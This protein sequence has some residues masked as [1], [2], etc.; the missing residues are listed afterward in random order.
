M[1]SQFT[2]EVFPA[3]LEEISKSRNARGMEEDEL[4]GPPSVNKDLVGLALSGGGI[5]SATFSLGVIQAL[6][7]IGVFRS[8]DY[9]STVSGGGYIGSCLSSVLNRPGASMATFRDSDGG[10]TPAVNYLRNCSNY[11]V[12]SGPVEKMR[13]PMIFLRGILLNIWLLIPPLI[14]TVFLTELLAELW[15]RIGSP[16]ITPLIAITPFIAMAVLYPLIRRILGNHFNWRWRNFYERGLAALFALSIFILALTPILGLVEYCIDHNWDGQI[17]D[18]LRITSIKGGA[19]QVA[20][21]IGVLVA[22]ILMVKASKFFPTV[23]RAIIN[24]IVGILG[25]VWVFMIYLVFCIFFVHSPYIADIIDYEDGTQKFSKTL[26]RLAEKPDSNSEAG[27]R[28]NL[29]ALIKELE[30]SDIPQAIP[31]SSNIDS[32]MV[33]TI[34][35]TSGEKSWII[36]AKGVPGFKIVPADEYLFVPEMS[37]FNL[38]AEWGFYSIGALILA[39]NF[40]FFD[41]NVTSTHGFYRDRLSRAFIFSEGELHSQVTSN[42]GQK[43]SELNTEGSIAPYHLINTTLNLTGSDSED[44]HGRNADFFT[45]SKRHCGADYTG[46]CKTVDAEEI[47]HSLDLAT[48]MAISAAAAAPN[49]GT[50]TKRYFV[51]IMTLL[52]VRL[53]YWMPNPSKIIPAGRLKRM[54]WPNVG[55]HFLLQEAFG[56]LNKHGSHI[57][58]SDGGHIENLAVYQLLKRRC[59]LIIAVDAEADP[60]LSFNGLITMIRFATIDLGVQIDLNLDKLRAD[61]SGQSQTHWLLATIRYKGGEEGKLLYLKSSLTGDEN[62]Y[63]KAYRNHDHTFPHQTTADQFFDETQ[64]EVYRSLGHHIAESALLA[65]E[66]QKILPSPS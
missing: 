3:E 34:T 9:L 14:L 38:E 66:V 24:T 40:F 32:I 25:P 22:I 12:E 39:L 31:L 52:N 56:R 16:R 65:E 62:E 4:D 21:I 61:E 50:G 6:D 30:R 57:N 59:K 37:L 23:V 49:M 64:F 44:L 1:K 7:Q 10:D 60:N 41:A 58:L 5:R 28:N 54:L 20:A 63:I 8:I 53:G 43:L 26:D 29:F 15:H 42:D 2:Q 55:P 51:F 36:S 33:E 46:Y 19:I 18:F 35:E 45:L 48:A 11:L 17:S 13:L 47:D 27:D